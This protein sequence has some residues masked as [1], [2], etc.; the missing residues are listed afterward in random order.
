[1]KQNWKPV[2]DYKTFINLQINME[3]ERFLYS[4]QLQLPN[5]TKIFW[6]KKDLWNLIVVINKEE[7]R[8]WKLKENLQV[9]SLYSNEV[10]NWKW[11]LKR[12]WKLRAK[13]VDAALHWLAGASLQITD[14]YQFSSWFLI[15]HGFQLMWLVI[16]PGLTKDGS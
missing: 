13:D 9:G 10:R 8:C 7:A 4:F 16:V 3:T 2:R 14:Y 1:M 12:K 5:M 6:I 15:S 11:K